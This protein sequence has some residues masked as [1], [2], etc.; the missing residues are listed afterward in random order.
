[1]GS[2]ELSRDWVRMLGRYMTNELYFTSEGGIGSGN[3]SMGD[4][5]V[6]NLLSLKF[7]AFQNGSLFPPSRVCA[8]LNKLEILVTPPSSEEPRG[9]YCL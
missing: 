2:L 3:M 8:L 7:L 9:A 6:V 1:M 4:C 5:Y